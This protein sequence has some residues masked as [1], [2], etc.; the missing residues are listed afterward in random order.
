VDPALDAGDQGPHPADLGEQDRYLDVRLTEGLGAWVEKLRTER[1]PDTSH[2]VQNDAP[3][4]VN[5]LLI[6][7]LRGER[8]GAGTAT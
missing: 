8:E 2:W 4:R 3:G 6:E 1:L 7:F 5:E